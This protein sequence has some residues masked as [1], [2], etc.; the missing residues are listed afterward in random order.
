MSVSAGDPLDDVVLRSYVVGAAHQALGWVRSEGV[1]VDE[2]G[3]VLDLTIRSFGIIP[4]RDM[5]PVDVVVDDDPRPPMPVGDTVSLPSPRR[6]GWR[7]GSLGRG[8][9]TGE[10]GREYA[11]R[12]LLTGGARRAVARVLGTARYRRGA[13]GPALV[14]GGFEGQARKALAN[15]ES[16]LWGRQLGWSHVVKTTVFLTDMADY[17]AFNLIYME[18]LGQHRPARSVVAVRA[19]PWGRWSRSRRG[20]TAGTRPSR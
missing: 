12:A 4:A 1:A 19:C 13:G 8:P 17:A 2:S 3:T 20:P 11:G 6:H 18:M 5:P 10:V 7:P 14:T 16:L 9:W 15:V